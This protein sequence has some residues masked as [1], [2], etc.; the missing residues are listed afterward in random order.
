MV[1]HHTVHCIAEEE[2]R[3]VNTCLCEEDTLH[4]DIALLS[5]GLW[6]WCLVQLFADTP[7]TVSHHPS[8][9]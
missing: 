1:D 3:K 2:M 5:K 9:P 8:W 6:N 7:I 4:L